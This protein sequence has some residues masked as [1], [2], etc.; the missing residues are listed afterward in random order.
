MRTILTAAVCLSF[1]LVALMA[2]S[3]ARWWFVLIGCGVAV[4]A[5]AYGTQGRELDHTGYW[6]EVM[7]SVQASD[8]RD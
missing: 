8:E 3:D 5:H 1:V 7:S 2:E 4:V 6:S